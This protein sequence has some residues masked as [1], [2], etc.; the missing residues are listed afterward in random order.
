MDPDHREDDAVPSPPT[1][2][3][4]PPVRVVVEA[5]EYPIADDGSRTASGSQRERNPRTPLRLHS[6]RFF[7]DVQP[8]FPSPPYKRVAS[9][10]HL[11]LEYGAQSPA[12]RSEHDL[13]LMSN[14]HGGQKGPLPGSE[15]KKPSVHY[16]DG[17]EPATLRSNA[18]PLNDGP[19]HNPPAP[20]AHKLVRTMSTATDDDDDDDE[21]GDDDYDWSADEDLG[22]EEA[23]YE[24]RMGK[25][26]QPK[27]FFRK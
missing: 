25:K 8:P 16:L 21:F 4:Q 17:T 3:S 26:I 7:D 1:I 11:T 5:E 15:S 2:S 6:D 22:G 19:A 24:Q 10:S 12:Y 14:E 13:P 9:S 20:M 18:P 23:K 27:G